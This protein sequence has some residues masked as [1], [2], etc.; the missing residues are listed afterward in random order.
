MNTK[1]SILWMKCIKM[2]LFRRVR[3]IWSKMAPQIPQKL[4]FPVSKSWKLDFLKRVR[5]I[6]SKMASPIPRLITFLDQKLANFTKVEVQHDFCIGS[7]FLQTT[8]YFW[9]HHL[10]IFCLKGYW[11]FG[12]WNL[13]DCKK[14]SLFWLIKKKQSTT[15]RVVGNLRTWTTCMNKNE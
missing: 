6:W 10:T 3:R 14:G 1:S 7:C 4:T 5:H 13:F 15:V 11:D 8:D 12:S 9:P 2:Q